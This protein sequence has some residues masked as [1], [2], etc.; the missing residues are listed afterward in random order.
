MRST[1]PA[2][3][4]ALCALTALLTGCA[5]TSS[6][7]TSRTGMEQL[8]ISDAVDKSLS[9]IDFRPLAGRHVFVDDQYLDCCDKGYVVSGVRHRVV[10]A[11]GRLARD[12]DSSDCV[13]EV[14]SG[15]VGTDRQE[16]YV[17]MD[18][19]SFPSMNVELP[20]VKLW[21]KDRQLATAKIGVM[22]YDTKTRVP[23]GPGGLSL[24]RSDD[25]NTFLLGVG[26]WQGGAVKQSI[27]NG[28]RS[29][30]AVD[31]LPY[32]VAVADPAAVPGSG[33]QLAAAAGEPGAAVQAGAR[34]DVSPAEPPAAPAVPA[35][36]PP[37]P[38]AADDPFDAAAP[39]FP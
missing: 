36:E 34:S 3:A 33:V 5:S 27:N 19:I 1:A 15:G 23:L 28:V 17:G 25:S 29:G 14:R 13:C 31:P 38:P 9:K 6:S 30:R 37:A 2:V 8:L 35:A 7:D 10:T 18:G 12:A 4:P 21:N 32:H 22:V 20:T 16:T 11:G 39:L 24:A 26:P